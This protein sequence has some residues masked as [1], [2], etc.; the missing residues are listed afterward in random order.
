MLIETKLA[1]NK[2]HN[3]L[4]VFQRI[5]LNRQYIAINHNEVCQLARFKRPSAFFLQTQAKSRCA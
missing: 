2:R 1:S 5:A 3:Y 4:N